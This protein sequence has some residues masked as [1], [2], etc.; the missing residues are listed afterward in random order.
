MVVVRVHV[1]QD[2]LR[3]AVAAAAEAVP[4]DAIPD[5]LDVP[6]V[7]DVKTDVIA[8]VQLLAVQTVDIHARQIAGV[9]ARN[10]ALVRVRQVVIQVAD[11]NFLLA[12][13]AN[14][15]YHKAVNNETIYSIRSILIDSWEEHV[16]V[17]LCNIMFA[18]YS[19]LYETCTTDTEKE[20]VVKEFKDMY[21]KVIGET[22]IGWETVERI[23][24]IRVSRNNSDLCLKLV[25]EITN[26]RSLLQF[27]D[28]CLYIY[29]SLVEY[30]VDRSKFYIEPYASTM[31][32][33]LS[34]MPKDNIIHGK[35]PEYLT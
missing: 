2:A 20:S 19:S 15:L 32:F 25:V 33:M 14:E 5:V 30:I 23:F 31:E 18:Y 4:A 6:H 16:C 10:H 28:S 29:K 34:N 17:S 1:V 7:L 3:H 11:L 35:S 12:I 22:Y 21:E 24:A 26:D 27:H 13:F 9:L 8:V